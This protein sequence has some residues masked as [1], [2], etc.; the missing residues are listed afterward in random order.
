MS[1]HN[2][3][4]TIKHKKEKTDAQRGKI[5]TKI[6]REI[7][8]AVREGGGADP[9]QNSRLRD[10]IAKAKAANMP[11]DNINRS[12]K[13]A[14]GEGEGANYKEITYEGYAPGGVA[15]IVEVVTDNLNRTA[16]EVR[17][18]FDKNGG[19]MGATGCV[20]W[21]FERKGVIELDNSKG[22]DED[23]LM[24]LALDAGAADVEVGD[25]MAILYTDPNDFSQVRENLEKAGC[26]FLE[27]ERAMVPNNTV[28]VSDPETVE[29]VRKLLDWLEDYDDTQNVYHNADLP[30]E[31]DEDE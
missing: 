13:K 4:S 14:A 28:E 3:W 5:F 16:S 7:A 29:K 30:E 8:I 20:A 11:N 22:L 9:E 27:A 31:D 19:S 21:M 18:I 17:H 24:M 15:V 2:K 1:G 10:V 6:G 23:E 12:I 26:T 25:G